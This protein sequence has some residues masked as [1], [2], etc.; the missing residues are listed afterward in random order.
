MITVSENSRADL[1]PIMEALGWAVHTCQMFEFSLCILL[2]L[3]SEHRL[4]ENNDAFAESWR[5]NS[6]KTLGALFKLLKKEIDLPESFKEFLWKGIE[7]RNYVT[8]E[9]F[10]DIGARI[11]DPEQR[12]NI[13]AEIEEIRNDIILRDRELEP[14]IDALLKKYKIST[15]SLKTAAAMHYDFINYQADNSKGPTLQ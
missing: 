2:S 12:L 9:F 13:A 3:L 1:A 8:H 4:P 14:L 6:R 11:V 5:A 7:L 15:E 10:E